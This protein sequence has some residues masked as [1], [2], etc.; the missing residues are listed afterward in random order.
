MKKLIGII[1]IVILSGFIGCATVTPPAGCE[2][3]YIFKNKPTFDIIM[4]VAITGVHVLASTNP[5][6]YKLAH[7][8]AQAAA[9]LLLKEPV[10]LSGLTDNLIINIMSPLLGLIPVDQVLSECDRK[11]LSKWFLMV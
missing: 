9:A 2:N 10:S 11:E 3:S 7:E 6:Q 4:S 5:A 1:C 8:S